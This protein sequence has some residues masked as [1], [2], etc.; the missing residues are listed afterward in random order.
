M[1]NIRERKAEEK[2]GPQSENKN[3]TEKQ[4]RINREKQSGLHRVTEFVQVDFFARL[5]QLEEDRDA[6]TYERQDF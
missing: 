5:A 1:K 6:L 4:I 2:K 3:I